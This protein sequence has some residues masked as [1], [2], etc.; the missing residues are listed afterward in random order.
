MGLADGE[1]GPRALRH[2]D[3]VLN[4]SF[5]PDGQYLAALKAPDWSKNP[6][7]LVWEVASGKAVIRVS[8]ALPRVPAHERRPDSG[9]T[10]G[11]SR[12]AT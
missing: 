5:S 2:D 12:H 10:V 6:E 11:P 8:H 3:I 7:L 9:R 4:V 1:R